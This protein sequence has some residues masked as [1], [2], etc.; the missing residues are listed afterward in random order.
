MSTALAKEIDLRAPVGGVVSSETSSIQASSDDLGNERPGEK[1]AGVRSTEVSTALPVGV[2]AHEKQFWFQR[3]K[4]NYDPNAIATQPS[5]FDDPDT[6]KE[7]QPPANW[8]ISIDLILLRDGLGAK[9]T[10]WCERSTGRSWYE[11]HLQS[12]SWLLMG[13]RFGHVS[14]LW[15]LNSIAPIFNKL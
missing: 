2:P 15:L 1:N 14:C 5:V 3:H 11:W 13:N 10:A 7:Y 6:A 4:T 12:R 8:K 9:T